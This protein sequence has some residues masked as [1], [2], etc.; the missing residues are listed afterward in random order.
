MSERLVRFGANVVA[1]GFDLDRRLADWSALR[2]KMVSRVPEAFT[3]DEWAYLVGFL[4]HD[5]LFQAFETSFGPRQPGRP[6]ALFRARGPI[7]VWLPNNVSLLGPLVLILCSFAGS[8]IRVKA[9]SRSDDLCQAFV[10][11]ALENL[12]PGELLEFLR[13]QVV[14]GRFD[15]DDQRN[16]EMAAAASVRIAFGSD[17]AVA[18]VHALP[19]PAGSLG[20]SFG[21]HRSEAWVELNA[22][23]ANGALG[24]L[25]VFAIYGS[26]GCTSPRRVV[27]L[28]GTMDDCAALRT[29]MLELWPRQKV[30]MRIASQNVVHSQLAAA[31]GWDVVRAPGNA[32]VLGI[33]S[34]ALPELTGPM[35]LALVPGTAR[36]AA[37]ALPANVQTVGYRLAAPDSR[38]WLELVA[39]TPIKRWVPLERMHHFEVVWDGANFWRQLF[40]EV[41][42]R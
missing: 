18:A 36:E 14:V 34:L 6:A 30:P 20:V 26:A 37:A 17:P 11:Y 10:S 8:P 23:D 31:A 9:G 38:V 22:L 28:D 24:L 13:G 15:R 5:S 3:R 27:I 21:D 2:L 7:A 32:A 4:A 25:K 29:R 1:L 35:S 19:H 39:E 40:E 12:P 42:I 33:G 41:A 16:Q